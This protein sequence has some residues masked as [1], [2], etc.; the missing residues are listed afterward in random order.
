[1]TGNLQYFKYNGTSFSLT[2]GSLI[3][4]PP[5]TLASIS[6][7]RVAVGSM[8]TL[9]GTGLN[10]SNSVVFTT[11]SGTT[12]DVAPSAATPTS[13]T[14]AVPPNTVTGP[15]FVRNGSQASASVVLEVT[16]ASGAQLQTPITVN[17]AA[18]ATGTDIYV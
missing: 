18:T 7:A 6:P 13:L 17:A 16:A 14:V 5:V 9:T 12:I 8:V 10:A 4:G 2:I 1:S 3:S 11:N 15:I